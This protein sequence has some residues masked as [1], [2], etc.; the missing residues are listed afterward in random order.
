MFFFLGDFVDDVVLDVLVELGLKRFLGY[1]GFL[2]SVW[3]VV[4]ISS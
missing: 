4:M 1:S 3:F 2:D